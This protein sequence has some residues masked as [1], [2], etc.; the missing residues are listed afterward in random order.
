M[1]PHR[2]FNCFAM[3]NH[4]FLPRWFSHSMIAGPPRKSFIFF[5]EN[6]KEKPSFCNF[7]GSDISRNIC[8]HSPSQ[9]Q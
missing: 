6:S 1:L 2:N 3:P 9:L 7:I 5:A 8:L 4:T